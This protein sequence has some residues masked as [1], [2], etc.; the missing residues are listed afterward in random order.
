MNSYHINAKSWGHH[1]FTF[2]LNGGHMNI[3]S[4]S[5]EPD[6]SI[7]ISSGGA[8]KFM[9]TKENLKRRRDKEEGGQTKKKKS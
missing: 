3:K 2:L 9:K 7:M 6:Q 5:F 4:A 1:V 8:L